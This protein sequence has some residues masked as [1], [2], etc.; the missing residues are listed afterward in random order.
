MC[1]GRTLLA[2]LGWAGTL[3]GLALCV[4][5]FLSAYVAFDDRSAAV[6]PRRDEVIR[7]PSVPEADVS[8]V[9]L[10]RP[11]APADGGG[12][13]GTL[14]PRGTLPSP[15]PVATPRPPA[16]GSPPPIGALNPPAP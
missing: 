14:A 15:T 13:A 3:G 8:R 16:D 11:H 1:Y 7:L 4:L 5:I 2:G 12:A 9:P 10:G 6:E